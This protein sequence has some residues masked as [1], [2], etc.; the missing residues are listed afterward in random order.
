MYTFTEGLQ[1]FKAMEGGN[2]GDG[3]GK[4]I[5]QDAN[6]SSQDPMKAQNVI[7]I[8]ANGDP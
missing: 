3:E 1:W 8:L 7:E 6:Q 5:C 4:W 2:V